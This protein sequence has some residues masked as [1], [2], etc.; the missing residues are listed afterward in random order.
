MTKKCDGDKNNELVI[1][2]LSDYF[3]CLHRQFLSAENHPP[4]W[5]LTTDSNYY[6]RGKNAMKTAPFTTVDLHAKFAVHDNINFLPWHR[7]MLRWFSPLVVLPTWGV[8]SDSLPPEALINFM[9]VIC[10]PPG[11]KIVTTLGPVAIEV[12]PVTT[13]DKIVVARNL[14]KKIGPPTL[15]MLLHATEQKS[16]VILP[17]SWR[18]DITTIGSRLL[19]KNDGWQEDIGGRYF[20]LATPLLWSTWGGTYSNSSHPNLF[21]TLNKWGAQSFLISIF[22]LR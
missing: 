11:G 14:G 10:L 15:Q 1:V 6:G 12:A 20:I 4:P 3:E 17:A 18:R 22:P 9:P 16:F 2:H 7:A 5:L 21:L 13:S 8:T 19:W